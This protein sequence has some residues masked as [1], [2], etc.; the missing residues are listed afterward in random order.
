MS[1]TPVAP[2][3]AQARAKS[4][5]PAN[6]HDKLEFTTS[7]PTDSNQLDEILGQT[8]SAEREAPRISKKRASRCPAK[9]DTLNSFS[10]LMDKQLQKSD[11]ERSDFYE[12]EQGN[13]E[14]HNKAWSEEEGD[15]AWK[16]I[17]DQTHEATSQE[18]VEK[19]P[20]KQQKSS[21]RPHEDTGNTGLRKEQ[22]EHLLHRWLG[23]VTTY[24]SQGSIGVRIARIFVFFIVIHLS[25]VSLL[26][27]LS[28]DTR[29]CEYDSSWTLSLFKTETQK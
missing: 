20:L 10:A 9:S 22:T 17:L 21:K 12:Q 25:V 2:L 8:K 11:Q 16:R 3:V 4:I 18:D 23:S 24:F 15:S 19:A 27:A 7:S 13:Y 14:N 26:Y 1:L 6:A 5:S 28:F 29:F